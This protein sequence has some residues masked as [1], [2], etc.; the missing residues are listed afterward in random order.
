ML[1]ESGMFPSTHLFAILLVATAC[2]SACVPSLGSWYHPNVVAAASDR[3]QLTARAVRIYA[4]D[5]RLLA[6]RGA[7][8]LGELESSGSGVRLA[9]VL[10]LAAHDAAGQGATH[11]MLRESGILYGYARAT[12]IL[13]RVER[14]NW[15]SLPTPLV[16]IAFHRADAAGVVHATVHS[17]LR[18]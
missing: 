1:S 9:E 12:F 4:G 2:L 6:Q 10:G 3:S 14:A 16:P 18:E 8:V 13:Y 17:A 5:D 7:V 15:S 11:M